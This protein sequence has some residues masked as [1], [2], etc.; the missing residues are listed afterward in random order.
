[1]NENLNQNNSNKV[2]KIIMIIIVIGVIISGFYVKT[3]LTALKQGANT[4]QAVE[5]VFKTAPWDWN[6]TLTKTPHPYKDKILKGKQPET[7][8]ALFIVYRFGCPDCEKAYPYICKKINE[9]SDN[10]KKNVWWVASR[11]KAGKDFLEKHPI[12]FVPSSVLRLEETTDITVLY[13]I[14]SGETDKNAI[15]MIFHQYSENAE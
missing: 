8:P 4:K 11:T 1:M 9:L 12:E 2:V 10:E 5:F 7:T 3:G 14:D 15:D 13:N 6:D